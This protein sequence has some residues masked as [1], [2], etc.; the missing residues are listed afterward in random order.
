MVQ[1]IDLG[2]QQNPGR[3]CRQALRQVPWCH[4]ARGG[5]LNME[6]QGPWKAAVGGDQAEGTAWRRL[7]SSAKP[8]FSADDCPGLASIRTQKPKVPRYLDASLLRCVPGGS[9]GHRGPIWRRKR[10]P[11]L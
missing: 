5:D 3:G 9:L 8:A 1:A 7:G 6:W 4:C 11:Y 10:L 2:Y